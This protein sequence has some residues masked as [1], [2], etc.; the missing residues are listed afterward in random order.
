MPMPERRVAVTTVLNM[1][2]LGGLPV[3]GGVIARDRV[4]RSGALT[5]LSAADAATLAA[6][7]I[8]T[9][10]DFRTASEAAA[11]PDQL[12]DGASTELLDVL[13]DS[14]AAAAANIAELLADPHR[15]AA[16]LG[17]G[18][19]AELL[20][21]S[22]RDI[23]RLPSARAAY[24]RF[25]RDLADPRRD[26]ALLFHCTA[27][28]D[29]TGWA[30]AALLSLLGADDD[31]IRADYLQTNDDFLPAL[32]P[33]LDRL[34]AAGIDPALITP[35]MGVDERYLDAA[36]SAATEQF[37]SMR[38]YFTTGLGLD[39][40]TLDAVRSRMLA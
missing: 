1:R 4:F 15:L 13:A 30:A 10:L 37:G 27:G 19:G 38:G 33:M 16:A 3:A 35:V 28:K 25:F 6:R 7:G 36:F 11:A 5:G 2:D 20:R 12:P 24:A 9:I 34:T 18:Q 39:G 40:V 17:D 29:R 32:R 22:Y 14:P 8:R 26:G 23:V 31:T 21:A